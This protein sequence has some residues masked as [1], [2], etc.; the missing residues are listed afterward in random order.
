[1][2]RML[3]DPDNYSQK[4]ISKLLLASSQD[5]VKRFILT[6]IKSMQM[7]NIHAHII[8]RFV[9]RS[10]LHLR[11][12]SPLDFNPEQWTNIKM[13]ILQFNQLKTTQQQ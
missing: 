8:A 12:F 13:A 9:D 2:T 5:E 7:H 10:L 11:A 6:A 1:M 3:P 4:L